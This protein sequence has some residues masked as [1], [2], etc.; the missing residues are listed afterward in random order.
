VTSAAL[1]AGITIRKLP[2]LRFT[3]STLRSPRS[4]PSG[5]EVP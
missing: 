4:S 2:D 3:R 5:V 1:C